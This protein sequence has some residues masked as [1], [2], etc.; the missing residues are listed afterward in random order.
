MALIEEGADV[1][2]KNRYGLTPLM[3][4]TYINT[5]PE[6]LMVLLE[7]GADAKAKDN[8]GKMALM[9]MKPLKNPAER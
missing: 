1:N 7:A 2:V 5:T 4:A 3:A 6:V 9:A 8:E